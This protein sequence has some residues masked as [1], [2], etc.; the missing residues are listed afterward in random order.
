VVDAHLVALDMSSSARIIEIVGVAGSGKS[1]L[2]RALC[3]QYAGCRV[4]DSLHTRLPAHWPY[5]AHSL[6]RVLPLVARSARNRPAWNWDEIKFVIY[7]SEW[8]RFLR[9]RPEHRSGVTVL[10]QGPIFALARLLW[11]KKPITTHRS[12]EIWLR[13]MVERWS[14][15]LD[16]IVWLVAPDEAL[17][18]RINHR[19]QRHEAK[20]KP[21]PEGLELIELHREAYGRLLELVTGVGRPRVLRFDT[22]TMSPAE[23][24]G[25]LADLFEE[26]S[27]QQLTEGAHGLN[28]RQQHASVQ[29]EN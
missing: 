25:E 4:A 27:G 15:E 17:L 10:D 18:A 21:V 26:P 24:A 19:E 28:V 16:A 2:T 11:G 23:I 7:V 20:G 12:F 1:T 6:P 3:A 22:S 5:V 9:D 8:D 13:R 14:V 29:E